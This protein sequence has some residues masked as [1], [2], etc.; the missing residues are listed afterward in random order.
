MDIKIQTL[1]VYYSHW[2]VEQNKIR[3]IIH[4]IN[5]T[6]ERINDFFINEDDDDYDLATEVR[7]L[8]TWIKNSQDHHECAFGVMRRITD[9]LLSDM[10]GCLARPRNFTSA[11]WKLASNTSS[12]VLDIYRLKLSR[13]EIR[14]VDAILSFM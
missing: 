10:G 5:T 6:M 9:N 11:E 14:S 7:F 12:H 13:D 1:M 8:K 4:G 2:G 3:K